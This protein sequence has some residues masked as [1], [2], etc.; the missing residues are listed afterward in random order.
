MPKL[1]NSLCTVWT[2]FGRRDT[3]AVLPTV[4]RSDGAV[5]ASATAASVTNSTSSF[6]TD[7]W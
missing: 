3:L 6:I 1:R 7:E 4:R 5:R 2:S